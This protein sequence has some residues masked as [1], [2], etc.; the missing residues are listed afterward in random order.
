LGFPI[1]QPG[2]AD[3]VNIGLVGSSHGSHVAGITAANDMLGNPVFDGAAPDAKI[4]SA[5]TCTSDVFC[6]SAA[7][8]DG[9]AELVTDVISAAASISQETWPRTPSA[10]RGCRPA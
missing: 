9:M 5:R 3:F 8:M 1:G 6:S 2:V 7:M 10:R 4:V